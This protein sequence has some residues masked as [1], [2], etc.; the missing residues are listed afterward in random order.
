[1]SFCEVIVN[2]D[3]NDF[4]ILKSK[5]P[6]ENTEFFTNDLLTLEK[7]SELGQKTSLI[8]NYFG[9]LTPDGD[10]ISDESIRRLK[11]FEDALDNNE[12]QRTSMVVGLRYLNLQS[13]LNLERM[14]K[15][16]LTKKNVVFLFRNVSFYY[17]AIPDIAK[18]TNHQNRFGVCEISH[19]Q[20]V[21]L[22]FESRTSF[23]RV[24]KNSFE[25]DRKDYASD[26]DSFALRMSKIQLK[27]KDA[28]HGFFLINNETDFYLKPIYPILNKLNEQSQNFVAFTF[29]DRTHKQL[30]EKRFQATNLLDYYEKAYHKKFDLSE[31]ISFFVNIIPIKNKRRKSEAR[32]IRFNRFLR[33]RIAVTKSQSLRL[34]EKRL[35]KIGFIRKFV[36][37]PKIK[38]RLVEFFELDEE[39][40][41]FGSIRLNLG[42]TVAFDFERFPKSDAKLVL[43]FLT[44]VEQLKSDDSVLKSY[45]KLFRDRNIIS[46]LTRI[47]ITSGIIE[48][49]FS[50]FNFK[51][52]F[53]A[54][55]ASPL[56]NVVCAVCKSHNIPTFSIPQLFLKIPKFAPILPTASKI[57]V[58]GERVKNEFTRLG[59]DKDRIV[60]TGSP[61][62]DYIGQHLKQKKEIKSKDSSSKKLIIVAMSRWH[63]G[64]EKWISQ[65]IHFCNDNSLDI[66]IKI[67][68]MYKFST[69]YDF[70]EIMIKK[71]RKQCSGLEYK[72]SY[73]AD[74]TKLLTQ[75]ELIITEYSIVAIEAAFS[76]IPILIADFNIEKD[77]DYSK[78]YREEGIALYST[79]IE[80]LCGNIEKIL[81]DVETKTRL[82]E[83]IRRFNYEFNHL[84]DGLA[85]QRVVDLLI[86]SKTQV[87]LN[88]HN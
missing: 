33:R 31:F 4:E 10:A 79:T 57:I 24:L 51:S 28:E 8:A 13:L 47:I 46:Y 2:F 75:A 38:S 53:V 21:T 50:K 87:S 59:M 77:S 66:L 60:V 42:S 72:I 18:E 69:N 54:A 70:S 32:R 1:M 41:G 84:N 81:H 85:A 61:R 71:I 25:T 43:D 64:D 48:S 58:S 7:M 5:I 29:D 56:N 23:F 3:V 14:R 11:F 83:A 19:S 16:L 20:L 40:G 80:Q 30:S 12:S 63:E 82:L 9:I 88:K 44:D 36:T 74:L 65:L 73:D 78:A 62:Y 86:D 6:L 76:E 55:D 22:D 49:I 17:F 37:R 34:Y 68:P 67:H 26:T 27:A 39:V 45:F 35:Y 15:I 52:V